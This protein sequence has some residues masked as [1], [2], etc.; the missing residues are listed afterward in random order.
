MKYHFSK[1]KFSNNLFYKKI[2]IANLE[3]LNGTFLFSI[4]PYFSYSG[5]YHIHSV[6][7]KDNNKTI[8]LTM[9]S[10]DDKVD[11]EDFD[12]Y[13]KFFISLTQDSKKA[14]ILTEDSNGIILKA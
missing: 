2:D 12:S 10:S 11:F 14:M 3:H 8:Y 4:F 13:N 9:K 6:I 5:L 7:H 1:S